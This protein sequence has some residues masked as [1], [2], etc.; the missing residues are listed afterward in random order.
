MNCCGSNSN[1]Y[2]KIDLK[3]KKLEEIKL[4]I[5][6]GILTFD[7]DVGVFR[8]S[9]NFN[10]G[11]NNSINYSIKKA[12]IE[13][14]E[15]RIKSR[16]EEKSRLINDTNIV[17][18]N[19]DKITN[20]LKVDLEDKSFMEEIKDN[21]QNYKNMISETV[22]ENETKNNTHLTNDNSVLVTIKEKENHN[23]S[24]YL[25]TINNVHSAVTNHDNIKNENFDKENSGFVEEII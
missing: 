17:S 18:D 16:L 1:S 24:G 11:K 15:L 25:D 19:I 4:K 14:L 21:F 12:Q 6:G 8:Q 13:E 3:T 22:N 5:N 20:L 23:Q 2:P 10:I 9:E 7:S